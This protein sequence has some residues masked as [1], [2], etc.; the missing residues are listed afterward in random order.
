M[1]LHDYILA[2][3][4]ST[5]R[6][7]ALS[8]K[9]FDYAESAVKLYTKCFYMIIFWSVK[10]L[11]SQSLVCKFVFVTILK[12]KCILRSLLTSEIKYFD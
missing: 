6:T 7:L 9:R 2:C 11:H 5:V 10:H 3:E 1:F 8:Y 12:C 4:I